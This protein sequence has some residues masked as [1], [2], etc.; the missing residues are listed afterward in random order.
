MINKNT[1][2]RQYN[3]EKNK[4]SLVILPK[5]STFVANIDPKTKFELK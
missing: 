1:C 2:F 4:K 3:Q 5:N